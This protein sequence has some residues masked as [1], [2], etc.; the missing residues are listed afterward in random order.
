MKK[1][2]AFWI[3]FISLNAAYSQSNYDKFKALFK[4][5]DTLQIP[6]LLEQWEKAS[7]D[8][9]EFYACAFNYYFYKSKT[10]V[11]ALE[12]FPRG[13]NAFELTDSTGK[14]AGF[15]NTVITYNN[16]LLNQALGYADKGIARFP[17][18]LDLRFGKC[19]VL[20]VTG[21]YDDF[22]SNVIQTIDYSVKNKNNW[23]WTLNEKKEDGEKFFVSSVYDYMVQLYNQQDDS[24]LKYMISIGKATLKHYPDHI[25]TLSAT[26]TALTLTQKYDQALVYLKHAETLNALDYIVLNNIANTYKLKGDKQNAIAYYEKVLKCGDSGAKIMAQQQIDL[27]RK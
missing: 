5:K 2:F 7:P 10:E 11:I 22:E 21:R 24:L 14:V 26:A 17:D 9:A 20:R 23:Q 27:L 8:D 16:P 12:P 4:E 15:M 3:V 1:I 13:N 18:R 25:E 19:Y 6:P